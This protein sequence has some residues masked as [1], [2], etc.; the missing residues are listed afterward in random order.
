MKK[1]RRGWETTTQE[2]RDEGRGGKGEGS[3]QKVERGKE[4]EDGKGRRREDCRKEESKDQG[5]EEEEMRREKREGKSR[6][7]EGDSDLRQV[8]KSLQDDQVH[9]S[10]HLNHPKE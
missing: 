8:L 7:L 6:H 1:R 2:G 3:G 10:I 5:E 4:E 9:P